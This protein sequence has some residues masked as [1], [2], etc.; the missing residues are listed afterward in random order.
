MGIARLSKAATEKGWGKRETLEN[1]TI[2][3]RTRK[4]RTEL[5]SSANTR[6][7]PVYH[8][9]SGSCGEGRAGLLTLFWSAAGNSRRRH[10][11]E[12]GAA[13]T[14]D[15]G[16]R[17]QENKTSA[18]PHFARLATKKAGASFGK[19]RVIREGWGERRSTLAIMVPKVNS[20][21]GL[22]G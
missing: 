10:G 18:N 15:R 8:Y 13:L 14:H 9:K 11:W 17:A 19:H 21:S 5:I 22:G 7:P 16:K 20:K 2:P 6:F 1:G 3:F 12:R 4:G